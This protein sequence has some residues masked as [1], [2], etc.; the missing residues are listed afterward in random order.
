MINVIKIRDR[1]SFSFDDVNQGYI[2]LNFPTGLVTPREIIRERVFREVL[3]YNEKKPEIFSG[4]VQPVGAERILNGFKMREKKE[5]DPQEQ[6]KKAV[7]A[8]ESNRFVM[9]VD[10]FQI[11]TLDEQIEIERDVEVTFLKLVPLVGG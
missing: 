8:F 5:I 6:Y 11:E 10:D 3:D 7:E 9:L 4:L 1:Q 2:T